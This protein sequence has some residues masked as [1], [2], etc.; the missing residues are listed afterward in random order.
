MNKEKVGRTARRKRK[1]QSRPLQSTGEKTKDLPKQRPARREK[2]VM[3]LWGRGALRVLW[4]RTSPTHKARPKS[5]Q[6][7]YPLKAKHKNGPE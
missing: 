3:A 5:L 4:K 7:P 6:N 1:P 2:G